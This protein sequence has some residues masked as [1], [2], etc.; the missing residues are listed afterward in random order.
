[1]PDFWTEMRAS[2]KRDN[3]VL[4]TVRAS[5]AAALLFAALAEGVAWSRGV[6]D[7]QWQWAIGAAS[8]AV[9][10]GTWRL[11]RRIF[12]PGERITYGTGPASVL[13][14]GAVTWGIVMLGDAVRKALH[15][16]APAREWGALVP[17]LFAVVAALMSRR[18]R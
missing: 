12:H 7:T 16:E 14:P 9:F 10:C 1:M 5:G 8:L 13:A 3:E 18:F 4:D 17:L 15:M 6:V 11:I 2:R